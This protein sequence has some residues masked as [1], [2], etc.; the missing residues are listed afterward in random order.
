[1]EFPRT[2]LAALLTAAAVSVVAPGTAVGQDVRRFLPQRAYLPRLYAGYREPITAAK[3][4]FV[5][6]SPHLFGELLEGEADFGASFPLYLMAGSSL[7][8]GFVFGVEAGIFSRWNMETREKDLIATDWIFA[9][10][11]VLHRGDHWLRFRYFHTS[12]HMGDEYIK[13]FEVPRVDFTRDELELVGLLQAHELLGVYAGGSWVLRRD[14]PDM[15]RWNLRGG[16]QFE[17]QQLNGGRPYAAVDVQLDED[18]A[19]KPQLTIH[20]GFHFFGADRARGIR[21][22]SEFFTGPAWQGQF[23][24]ENTTYFTLGVIIDL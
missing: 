14:P 13:V 3:G 16:L 5:T 6:Q 1:V 20:A 11:F 15:K 18:D 10:P 19:W 2:I 22:I 24:T 7:E 17:A 9:I 4:V 12:A 23:Y 8:D 21:L